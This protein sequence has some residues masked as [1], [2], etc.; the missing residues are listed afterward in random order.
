M[1]YKTTNIKQK[2]NIGYTTRVHYLD[3]GPFEALCIYQDQCGMDVQ[4]IKALF[5]VDFFVLCAK[6]KTLFAIVVAIILIIL[7]KRVLSIIHSSRTDLFLLP[8]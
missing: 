1:C 6:M 7:I 2:I 3:L 4:Y 8:R 5:I